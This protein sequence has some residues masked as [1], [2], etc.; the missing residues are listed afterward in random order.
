M[1]DKVNDLE[2][3][4]SNNLT[5]EEFSRKSGEQFKDVIIDIDS[6]N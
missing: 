2:K 6:L 3:T 4:I 5:K 1:K